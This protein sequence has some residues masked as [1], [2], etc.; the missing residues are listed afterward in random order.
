MITTTPRRKSAER[1]APGRDGT[2]V[3]IWDMRIVKNGGQ[4]VAVFDLAIS[5]GAWAFEV[6]AV[7][8]FK[9]GSRRWDIALPVIHDGNRW[10]NSVNLPLQ[11]LIATRAFAVVEYQRLT[12][13]QAPRGSKG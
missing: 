9:A 12:A 7:R 6:R 13:L 1:W 11:I 4:R 2:I 10:V 3:K 8:L 5:T